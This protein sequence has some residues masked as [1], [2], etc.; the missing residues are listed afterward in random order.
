MGLLESKS[1]FTEASLVSRSNSRV[2]AVGVVH[3]VRSVLSPLASRPVTLY[4]V[5]TAVAL[6][7]LMLRLRRLNR[8]LI[9]RI[10]KKVAENKVIHER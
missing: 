8:M 10:V 3:R 5:R 4:R 7:D 1:G 6:L 2:G 9:N